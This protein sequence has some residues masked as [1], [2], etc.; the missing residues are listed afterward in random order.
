MDATRTKPLK[1]LEKE[2]KDL[3]KDI[4]DANTKCSCLFKYLLLE[5]IQKDWETVVIDQCY[6]KLGHS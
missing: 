4:S 5:T 1:K 3:R 6:N 2:I